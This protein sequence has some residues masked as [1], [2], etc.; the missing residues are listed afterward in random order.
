MTD[1]AVA[2]PV[3]LHEYETAARALL[4]P[5]VY[6]FIA[7]GAGDEVTLRAN[8][9]AFGRWRLLPRVLTGPGGVSTAT[10]VLGQP[11]A[12]PVLIAPT[13]LHGQVHPDGELATARAAK[14]ASTIYTL[15]SASNFAIEEVG[16]TAGPWWFQ[17]YVFKDRSIT[18][19]LVERA[20]AAG[21][22]AIV[23]TVDVPKLGR[24]E[25][26]ERNR[27]HLAPGLAMANLEAAI[28][29]LVPA[30]DGGS[31]MTAYVDSLWDAS[32]GWSDLDWLAS[33]TSL[34]IVPKG[35]LHPDDARLAVEHGARAIMVSNH[36]GR[37]LDGAIAA[38]D[39]LPAVAEAVGDRAEV[40]VDG[41]I[42]RGT[43]VIKAL[44]L[45]ARATLIGR[46]LL[47]GLA[48]GGE[49]GAGHVLGLLRAELELDL[50]LCGL[51]STQA[52]P[53]SVLVDA[54]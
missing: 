17:L 26:D 36:G 7:G 1:T 41:G 31:G 39:A 44:A 47:W 5:M 38:L 27:Y 50:L 40:L 24:R 30:A 37:Q 45:G 23:L 8:R 35:I 15:S 13:G 20:E 29:R 33:I 6:E 12:L 22:S 46:P 9:E 34:P 51:K 54:R 21:A 4:S 43:D 11:V 25:A 3:N 53:R 19:E 42:R 18:R 10:T 48:V 2:V 16:P 52:V 49:A 28:H 14:A 32:I